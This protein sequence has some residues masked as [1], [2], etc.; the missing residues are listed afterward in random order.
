MCVCVCVCVCVEEG[1][2]WFS[3][4]PHRSVHHRKVFTKAVYG[5]RCRCI[6][7][8]HGAVP[9]CRQKKWLSPAMVAPVPAMCPSR[10]PAWTAGCR[11]W[12]HGMAYKRQGA[13]S[14]S[15]LW[16]TRPCPHTCNI[17]RCMYT[18]THKR[19]QSHSYSHMHTL[20]KTPTNTNTNTNINTNTNTPEPS[21]NAAT[22]RPT[23]ATA[24]A[25]V[26]S[27]AN[28]A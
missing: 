6:P 19:T 18:P 2:P 1:Y 10:E 7:Q 23:A 17:Y 4:R 13:P 3:R 9:R 20:R 15:L 25:N 12:N 24:T 21:Y 26:V 14:R 27:S 28:T 11:L 16:S 5:L 8:L 22:M